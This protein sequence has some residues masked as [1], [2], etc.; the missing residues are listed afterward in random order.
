MGADREGTSPKC[1]TCR[2]T[3]APIGRSVALGMAG[4][5]CDRDCEGYSREPRADTLWPGELQSEFGY[6]CILA[7]DHTGSCEFTQPTTP[8]REGD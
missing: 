2:R 6:G 8:K 4:S 5:L 7:P 1:A 3:K